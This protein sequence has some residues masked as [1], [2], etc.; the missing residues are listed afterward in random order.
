MNYSVFHLNVL[1]WLARKCTFSGDYEKKTK[2]Y[3]HKLKKKFESKQKK[4]KMTTT[5]MPISIPV[6]RRLDFSKAIVSNSNLLKTVPEV[7][8]VPIIIKEC[9]DCKEA[10]QCKFSKRQWKLSFKSVRRCQEC[11]FKFVSNA[12]INGRVT[13]SGQVVNESPNKDDE[14]LEDCW[15]EDEF[16]SGRRSDSDNE[17]ELD[18]LD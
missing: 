6:R 3:N 9:V 4:T 8:E 1:F 5:T 12:A 10:R 17:W 13:R 18:G 14:L 11:A 15:S 2:P 7:P 16:D